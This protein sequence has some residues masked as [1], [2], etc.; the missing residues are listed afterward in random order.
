MDNPYPWLQDAVNQ[1]PELLQPLIV[2]LAAAIP[3][4][5]GEGAA[6][7]GIL[8]GINPVV[9]AIAAMAGNILCV[10]LVVLLGSR[11]RAGA[12]SRRAEKARKASAIR[13]TAMSEARPVVASPLTEFGVVSTTMTAVPAARG[14][15]EN[16]L[17][18]P[19]TE[20]DTRADG[21]PTRGSK[22]REKLRRW[23]VKFG[24]PGASLIAPL[25]LPTM[26]TAAFFVSS[27]V[28]KEWVI[29]WQVIAII[30]W[31]SLFAVAATGALAVLGW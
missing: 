9:A 7:I 15:R 22:G 21:K 6:G 14:T 31:T 3:Y 30:V 25:A 5:E 23:L 26:L 24:V 16:T 27:G 2:A 17:E 12:V 11:V 18:E 20:T 10:V 1:M 19:A 4:I 8:A 28:R 13:S 29:L